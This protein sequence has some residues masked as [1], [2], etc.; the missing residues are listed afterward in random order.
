MEKN[1]KIYKNNISGT[2][3]FVTK[4]S[5]TIRSIID[6]TNAKV[7]NVTLAEAVVFRG[8]S[9]M[10]HQHKRTE[11][12]YYFT[13]GRGTMIFNGKVKFKVK[14]GDGV[15]IP[16]GT[17]HKVINTGSEDIK[18]LC[19][20]APP[21]SHDDTFIMGKRYKLVIFDFDGTLVDSATGIWHTANEMARIFKMKKFERNL[22][23]KTVGTGLDSFLTDLFPKQVKE[24]GMK[25]TMNIY[26]GIYDVMYKDGLKVFKNVK[27][28]LKFLY[29]RGVILAVAS[30]KLKKYVDNINTEIGISEYFDITFGSED[31]LRK[32][33]DPFVVHHLM[34]KYKVSKKEVLFVGD[35]Q[36]DVMTAKNAG[37]DCAF[38]EYGYADRKLIKKLKP[39]FCLKD[40][41]DLSEMV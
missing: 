35:S 26:R 13:Q 10:A 30:N 22:I 8:R 9:T 2:K 33:P 31:V 16:P 23:V 12:I 6:S 38:L 25:K 20:C 37:V 19:V 39:E 24:M 14:K 18:I 29:A 28:T 11:E 3:P 41:G 27:Q 36:Y 21:Y 15:L 32:K 17:T 1:M 34:K 4:D 40:F 7:K 5:S